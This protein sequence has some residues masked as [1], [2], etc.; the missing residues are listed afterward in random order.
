MIFDYPWYFLIFCLLA[1]VVYAGVLYFLGSRSFSPRLRWLLAT[2]RFVVVT[3]IAM[4]LLAPTVRRSVHEQ[5]RPL[6]VVAKD[7]SQSVG[8]SADSSYTLSL[9]STDHYEVVEETFGGSYTDLAGEMSTLSSRYP[10]RDIGAL[11]LVT[12]GIHNRGAGPSSVAEQ[13][14][15]PVYSVALGDT[16]PRRDAVLTA[17]R[18]NKIAYSGNTF[19]VEVTVNATLL[20]GHRA[21]LLA[22]DE[23]GG[24]VERREV[25]YEGSSFSLPLTLSL[26][27]GDAGLHRYQLALSVTEG[28]VDES[29]NVMTFYVDVVDSRRRVAIIAAA[30]HPDLGALRRAIG[31]HAGYRA[32]V[33]LASE[34]ARLAAALRDS[35]FS[36]VV[37]HNLP[38]ATLAVPAAVEKMPALY[39]VGCQTDL[40]RFNSLHTGLEIVAKSKK[41]NEVTATYNNAFS[42]FSYG[43]DDADIMTQMPPLDAPFGEAHVSAGVQNLFTAR[44][45]T[46]DTRQPLIAATTQ[47]DVHRSFVW[48]E[49][50]WRWRLNDYQLTSSHQHFDRLIGQL[51]NLTAAS[52]VRSPFVVEAQRLYLDS[53]PVVLS[54]QLYNEAS[55]P[56]NGPEAAVT[57]SGDGYQADFL[58]SRDGDGYRLAVGQLPEGL[59]R[60]AAHVEYNGRT[61]DATGAFAVEAM[62]LERQNLVA[63]H[64]LL[65]TIGA[66]TGGAT[67]LPTETAALEEAMSTLRPIVYSHRRFDDLLSLPWVLALILLL[68]TGEWFIRKYNG[69]L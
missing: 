43:D 15:F 45:G 51:V 48:G 67:Y 52:A 28:E 65:R 6:V 14:T 32:D 31:S 58:F 63:D 1:G 35:A 37:L 18:Y 27:A 19:V 42:L 33:F 8:L 49:G 61:Y 66:V 30:P 41:S 3:V 2:L 22:K 9:P 34:T 10:G 60:Y 53:D 20:G 16:L 54:A 46:I 57:L 38:T 36:M 29:N 11:V 50:L 39:I 7:V 62:N 24:V 25:V 4:L 47:G 44:L 12:D 17:L 5:Q 69:T 55:E 56:I 21:T 26:P 13:L 40:P 68:M 23:K 59:Y 64:A